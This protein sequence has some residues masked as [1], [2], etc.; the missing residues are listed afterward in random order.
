[1]PA[2]VHKL[3][4]GTITIGETG[5]TVDFSCQ[6]TAAH[7][8]WEAD[9]GDDVTVLCG[10]VVPGARTYSATF[11]GTLLQDLDAAGIVA[12]SW[13]HRGETVPFSF[14]PSTAAAAKVEGALILDPLSVGGD[15]AGQNMTSDFEWKVAGEPTFTPTAVALEGETEGAE[16]VGAAA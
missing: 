14:T 5:T 16:P 11:A 9:E 8:D 1:M 4:P 6:V 15:E 3:G 13:E 7:I 10:D 2:K 12:Y